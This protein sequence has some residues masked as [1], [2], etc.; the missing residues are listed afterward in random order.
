MTALSITRR[1]TLALLLSAAAFPAAA[2]NRPV[3]AT[4]NYPL[5]YF[6]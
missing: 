5:A 2:Q 1:G 6:V 3:V 4:D